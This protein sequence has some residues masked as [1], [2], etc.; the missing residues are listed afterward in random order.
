[1]EVVNLTRTKVRKEALFTTDSRADS[2]SFSADFNLQHSLRADV[3]VAY[4]AAHLPARTYPGIVSLWVSAF[5]TASL[6]T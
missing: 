1:M 5:A 2:I 4:S 6:V 3:S